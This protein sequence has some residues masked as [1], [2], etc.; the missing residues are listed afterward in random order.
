MYEGRHSS[1]FGVDRIW[2]GETK[3]TGQH[4]MGTLA[5]LLGV[6]EHDN[7]NSRSELD[8]SIRREAYLEY[9]LLNISSC[10]DGRL[11]ISFYGSTM[12]PTCQDGLSSLLL[13]NLASMLF[14]RPYIATRSRIV[15]RGRYLKRLQITY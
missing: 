3:R 9:Y 12:W 7:H 2:S 6:T 13:L 11:G 15:F 1:N 5:S 4:T 14:S 8:C 10:I